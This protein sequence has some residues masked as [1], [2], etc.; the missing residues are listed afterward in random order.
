MNYWMMCLSNLHE[1]CE[2]IFY[3]VF[4]SLIIVFLLY[5]FVCDSNDKDII[6]NVLKKWK[7]LISTILF[8][9]LLGIIFIPSKND[10]KYSYIV[11]KV[12]EYVN[13]TDLMFIS[14]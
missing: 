10:I 5:I 6:K 12:I 4:L 14:K 2:I 11:D 9:S 8:A 1:V 3:L 7:H 13:R